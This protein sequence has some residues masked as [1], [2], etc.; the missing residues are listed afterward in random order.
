MLG[1]LP[2]AAATA[3]GWAVITLPPIIIETGLPPGK[4]NR[5]EGIAT[6]GAWTKVA[7]VRLNP[8]VTTF[9]RLGVKICVSCTLAVMPSISDWVEKFGSTNG[10]ER[11]PLSTV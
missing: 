7:N 11:N 4:N 3:D 6:A 9:T 10:T 2:G 8:K 5:F 1:L